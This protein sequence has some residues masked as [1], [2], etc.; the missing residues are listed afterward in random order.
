MGIII[1]VIFLYIVIKAFNIG[2][3][4]LKQKYTQKEHDKKLDIRQSIGQK[5]QYIITDFLEKHDGD[6]VQ[7]VEFSN[8][9]TSVAYLPFRYM[10][11]TYEVCRPGSR[12]AAQKIDKISTSLFTQF[13]DH[14][15]DKEY[16]VFDVSNHDV[17]VG[18]A[19]YD[20][21]KDMG[22]QKCIC[23]M[24]RTI[25]GKAVGYVAFYKSSAFNNKDKE[26]IQ[27]LADSISPLVSIM[28][29]PKVGQYS[30]H[31]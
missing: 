2:V 24:L 16:C 17:L 14:L 5:I 22:E 15:Q 11:C 6:R 9:V 29:M 23:A 13:F 10:T 26:G 8:S 28:D 30:K 1:S 31:A 25:S 27:Q 18:G 20:L 7:V 21:I 3:D 19:M 12:S 4:I